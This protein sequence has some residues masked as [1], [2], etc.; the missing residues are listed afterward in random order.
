MAQKA[1][2]EI[3]FF[4][5]IVGTCNTL[6]NNNDVGTKVRVKEPITCTITNNQ[7]VKGNVWLI[8][9]QGS[10]IHGHVVRGARINDPI[11]RGHRIAVMH[12][13]V[14]R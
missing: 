12:Y 11:L 3:R 1:E 13:S 14:G 6:E 9:R 8:K 10:N 2:T 7:Y 5:D 4:F